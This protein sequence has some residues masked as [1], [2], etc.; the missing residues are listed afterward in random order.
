MA[1]IEINGVALADKLELLFR[2]IFSLMVGFTIFI[3]LKLIKSI[4]NNHHKRVQKDEAKKIYTARKRQ[5]EN[6]QES[7]KKWRDANYKIT[8]LVE[9]SNYY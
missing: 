9:A 4:C 2:V 5:F 3:C 1:I 7:W 8:D 6:N